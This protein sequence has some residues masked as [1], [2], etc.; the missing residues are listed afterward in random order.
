MS[1]SIP[2]VGRRQVAPQAWASKFASDGPHD[3]AAYVG[4]GV[5]GD[6]AAVDDGQYVTIALT[7]AA[8][9]DGGSGGSAAVRIGF[10]AGDVNGSR[11]V[12]LSDLLAVN[13]VL[14]QPVTAAN[15]LHD[16]NASGTLTLADKLG[17]NASLTHALPAP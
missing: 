10:L 9:A 6:P 5:I 13:N 12:T 3:P 14:T 1:G 2:H 17:V 7:S 11:T 8:A 4:S 15:F 16:V